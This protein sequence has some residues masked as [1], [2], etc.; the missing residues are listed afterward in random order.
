VY[1]PNVEEIRGGYV[2]GSFDWFGK[3]SN[4]ANIAT[5]SPNRLKV[6]AQTK[7]HTPA[8]LEAFIGSPWSQAYTIVPEINM[9]KARANHPLR[10]LTYFAFRIALSR[11]CASIRA[12]LKYSISVLFVFI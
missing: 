7:K 5:R 8:D 3:G 11:A 6:R 10:D 4:E 12:R 2:V 1:L 9:A